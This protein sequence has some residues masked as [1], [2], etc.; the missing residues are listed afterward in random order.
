MSF[1]ARRDSNVNFM[2]F[3]TKSFFSEIYFNDYKAASLNTLYVWP[4]TSK[5][6][7]REKHKVMTIHSSDDLNF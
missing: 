1:S 6:T 3:F 5:D 4:I 2:T 7:D